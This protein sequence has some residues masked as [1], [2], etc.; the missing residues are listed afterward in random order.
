MR[1]RNIAIVLLTAAAT[2]TLALV[3]ERFCRGSTAEATSVV[4]PVI[5]QP[6]LISSGCVFKV[7]TD[8]T[9]YLAGQSPII[10]VIGHNPSR[11]PVDVTVKVTVTSTARASRF[12][13]LMPMPDTLCDHEFAFRLPSGQTKLQS[14]NSGAK[15]PAGQEILVF[16]SDKKDSVLTQDLTP[17]DK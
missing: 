9:L 2:A 13:R 12:A 14:V 16:L 3:V 5:T 17:K 7:K 10:T 4:K 11:I 6:E 15:L 1:L 8:K